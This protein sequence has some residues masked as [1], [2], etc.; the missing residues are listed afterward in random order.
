MNFENLE[1]VRVLARQHQSVNRVIIDMMNQLEVIRD[2]ET[3]K[4]CGADAP[5]YMVAK[6]RVR[7]ERLTNCIDAL[8][9]ISNSM[10]LNEEHL[11]HI[12]SP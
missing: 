8:H 10:D 2:N 7:M 5:S 1:K 11:K 3:E 9:T 12:T 6:H 4:G